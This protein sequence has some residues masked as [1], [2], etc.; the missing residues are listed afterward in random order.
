MLPCKSVQQGLH[1]HQP[2]SQQLKARGKTINLGKEMWR[3]WWAH[4]SHDPTVM[5]TRVQCEA[6]AQR[7]FHIPFSQSA[8]NS[9]SQRTRAE[10]RHWGLL[11]VLWK[12][13]SPS[14]NRPGK[15]GVT[16]SYKE[17]QC[18]RAKDVL[19]P[20]W[21]KLWWFRNPKL[22]LSHFPLHLFVKGKSIP[23]CSNFN[24]SC[25]KM[26]CSPAHLP[27]PQIQTWYLP[28]VTAVCKLSHRTGRSQSHPQLSSPACQIQPWSV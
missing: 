10:V 26:G 15:N 6:G 4:A 12:V 22:N 28:G 27:L 13:I 3:P 23:L 17:M 5:T 19:G 24:A 25:H 18:V 16:F 21:E 11:I 20:Q 1:S 7:M 8:Q 9:Q 2:L 14:E